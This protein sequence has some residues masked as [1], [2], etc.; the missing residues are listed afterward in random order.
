MQ[1]RSF[2][3]TNKEHISHLFLAL[4]LLTFKRFSLIPPRQEGYIIVKSKTQEIQLRDNVISRMAIFNMNKYL[5]IEKIT[6]L[7]F[8]GNSLQFMQTEP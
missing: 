6:K 4:I 3:I 5:P 2:F 1:M 7:H 8:L